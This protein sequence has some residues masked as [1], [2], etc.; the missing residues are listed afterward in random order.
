MR[1][2]SWRLRGGSLVRMLCFVADLLLS[3][4]CIIYFQPY[5][6]S[7]DVRVEMPSWTED[8]LFQ[9]EWMCITRRAGVQRSP[10]LVYVSRAL[11]ARMA[12]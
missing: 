2:A 6:L 3:L 9:E 4:I 10:G 8:Q 1:R 5:R 7:I 12:T 11:S